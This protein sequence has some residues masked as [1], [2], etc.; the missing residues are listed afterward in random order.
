[1]LGLSFKK[2]ISEQYPVLKAPG[3]VHGVAPSLQ[4]YRFESE[5]GDAGVQ[6]AINSVQLFC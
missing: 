5:A 1:M 3:A 2:D 6:L 4:P